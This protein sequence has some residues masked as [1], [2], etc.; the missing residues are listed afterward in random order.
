MNE[1][2][3]YPKSHIPQ[4]VK[5]D[6]SHS[7]FY[8]GINLVLMNRKCRIH[9]SNSSLCIRAH[10]SLALDAAVSRNNELWF[11]WKNSSYFSQPR[12]G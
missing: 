11:W 7:S 5:K 2:Y 1:K 8:C 4:N 9:T 6:T 12:E 10:S 3:L